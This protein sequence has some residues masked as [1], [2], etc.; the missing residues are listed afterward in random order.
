M[1]I[2]LNTSPIIFLHKVNRLQVLKHCV[3]DM[4]APQN[5]VR[6][7]G[8]YVLPDFMRSETLSDVGLSYVKGAMGR[9][10]E[11]ELAAIVLAQELS[12]DFVI[13]DDLLA[14][15]K[16]QQLDLNVM[17]TLGLL[18]LMTKQEC[19]TPQQA[20]DDITDLTTQHG[21]YLSPR[22]LEHIKA[23]LFLSAH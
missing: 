16:A 14:R 7:L 21:M 1:K 4:I 15:Q 5:V 19:L 12:A 18:L 17:G 9:L 10:H 8:D 6:E 22:M 20:W 11:G 23:A 3:T 13:L 2:V